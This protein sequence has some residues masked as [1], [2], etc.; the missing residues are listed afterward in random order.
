MECNLEFWTKFWLVSYDLMRNV[1]FSAATDFLRGDPSSR[2]AL[3]YME[4]PSDFNRLSMKYGVREELVGQRLQYVDH[5]VKP[6]DLLRRYPEAALGPNRFRFYVVN[7]VDSYFGQDREQDMVGLWKE[8]LP[9]MILFMSPVHTHDRHLMNALTRHFRRFALNFPDLRA[10][11]DGAAIPCDRRICR[12][13]GRCEL[14]YFDKYLHA[15]SRLVEPRYFVDEDGVSYVKTAWPDGRGGF[16][17][18]L[19]DENSLEK[20]GGEDLRCPCA[21]EHMM[22]AAN[23]PAE[24]NERFGRICDGRMAQ[25]VWRLNGRNKWKLESLI[26]YENRG[27]AKKVSHDEAPSS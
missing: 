17:E 6:N 25:M 12:K 23:Q 20:D 22:L 21:F 2:K 14:R 19:V 24:E 16:R 27:T 9:M 26:S 10:G 13:C 4:C 5:Y 7:A 1:L 15:G 8:I 18:W 11:I 3:V